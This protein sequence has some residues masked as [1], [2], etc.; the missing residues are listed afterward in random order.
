MAVS[1]LRGGARGQDKSVEAMME[2][3]AIDSLVADALADPGLLG[4]AAILLASRTCSPHCPIRFS[5]ARHRL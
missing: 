2:A 5:H 1:K 3:T 4:M